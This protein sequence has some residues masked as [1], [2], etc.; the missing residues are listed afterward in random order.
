MFSK[1]DS[2]RCHSKQVQETTTFKSQRPKKMYNIFQTS[3]VPAVTL[4]ILWSTN[5]TI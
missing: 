5:N 3:V 2:I 4:Y 1:R